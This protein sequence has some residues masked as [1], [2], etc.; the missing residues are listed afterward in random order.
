MIRDTAVIVA[1]IT[2][3]TTVIVPASKRWMLF[4]EEFF[5]WQDQHEDGH[6][7][8]RPTESIT[9]FRR[10]TLSDLHVPVRQNNERCEC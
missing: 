8:R 7:K 4:L 10:A 9:L 2:S 1:P 6:W 3:C 5:G